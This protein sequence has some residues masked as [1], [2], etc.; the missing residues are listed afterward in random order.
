MFAAGDEKKRERDAGSDLIV[1]EFLILEGDCALDDKLFV[2][3]ER[4]I[5]RCKC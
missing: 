2:F 5:S 3:A 4:M 1:H